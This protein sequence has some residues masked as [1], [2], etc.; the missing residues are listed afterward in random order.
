V[1]QERTAEVRESSAEHPSLHDSLVVAFDLSESIPVPRSLRSVKRDARS[2]PLR[3]GK[4][5]HEFVFLARG[6]GVVVDRTDF[7]QWDLVED[8]RGRSER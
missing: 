6:G 4:L 7:F 3:I 1:F 5:R 8:I 2:L